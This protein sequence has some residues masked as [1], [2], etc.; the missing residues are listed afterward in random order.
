M[1]KFV[2]YQ[3]DQRPRSPDERSASDM[4]EDKVYGTIRKIMLSFFVGHSEL[5]RC[6]HPDELVIPSMIT[7]LSRPSATTIYAC[8]ET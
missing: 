7:S 4:A 5:S 2:S 6:M 8:N 3:I 1:S